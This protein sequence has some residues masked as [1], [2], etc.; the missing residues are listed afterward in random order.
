MRIPEGTGDDS[1]TEIRDGFV[2]LQQVPKV[3]NI[4]SATPAPF[5]ML[6]EQVFHLGTQAS[7]GFF[8][9]NEIE[10]Q[11]LTNCFMSGLH[12]DSFRAAEVYKKECSLPVKFI[13]EKINLFGNRPSVISRLRANTGTIAE[14]AHLPES[15]KQTIVESDHP[16]GRMYQAIAEWAHLPESLKQTI[17][18]SGH[19]PGQERHRDLIHKPKT[20]KRQCI[21]QI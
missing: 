21:C 14:W 15:L 20:P 4:A 7:A 10:E 9:E 18:E 1:L 17:V 6:F 16:P 2:S 5:Q 3:Q 12:K 8:I 19:P 11:L 13:S